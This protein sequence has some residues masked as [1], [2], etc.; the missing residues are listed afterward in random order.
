MLLALQIDNGALV[1]AGCALPGGMSSQ[2]GEDEGRAGHDAEFAE[3]HAEVSR[4]HRRVFS[5]PLA[6]ARTKDMPAVHFLPPKKASTQGF[7]CS[8]ADDVHPREILQPG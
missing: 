8:C 3:C 1:L 6:H 7:F 2:Q 4:R 5:L